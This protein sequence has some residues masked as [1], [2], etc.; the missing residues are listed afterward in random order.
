MS[1][2]S[3]YEILDSLPVYG[4]MYVPIAE[5]GELFYSEGIAVR[6]FKANGTNWVANFKPGWTHFTKVY[7]LERINALLVIARGTCYLINPETE[8]P[9]AIF[10]IGF[11]NSF[12]IPNQK[13]VLQDQTDL[14]VIEPDGRSWTT[15]R[16]SFDE[17]RNL[18]INENVIT[19][20]S[21]DPFNGNQE[22]VEF[23]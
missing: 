6:F 3:Q 19:G 2:S 16:I 23:S 14:T 22:W 13:I 10:G 9:I 18:E 21:Y 1:L 17:L 20:L 5:G 12:E 8:I 15:E 7:E 4:P 11:V